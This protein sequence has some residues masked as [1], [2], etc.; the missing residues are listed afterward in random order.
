M[1]GWSSGWVNTDGTTAV[2]NGATLNFTHNL[3]TTDFT[4]SAY[5]ADDTNGTNTRSI[6]QFEI[7]L[8]ANF[9]G[10]QIQNIDP[11]TLTLQLGSSGIVQFT[12]T[13]ANGGSISYDGKYIKVVA[14]A[15][16]SAPAA[17]T[18]NNSSI[19]FFETPYEIEEPYVSMAWTSVAGQGDWANSG[20]TTLVVVAS[21]HDGDI[22][23][24]SSQ[25]LKTRAAD[26]SAEVTIIHH[27]GTSATRTV[28]SEQA[29]I[30]CSI[31]GSFEYFHNR[32]SGHATIRQFRVIGYMA[33]DTVV[34]GAGDLCKILSEDSGYQMFRNGLTMQWMSSPAF[35]TES[36]QVVNFPIPFAAKPFKVVAGTRFPSAAI[37]THETIQTTSWN[38]TS[39]TIFAQSITA[40]FNPVYADIIAI[41]IA[42]VTDCPGDSSDP[43]GTKISNLPSAT[44]LKD[45]DLFVISKENGNDELYDASLNLKLSDLSDFIT[46]RIPPLTIKKVTQSFEIVGFG[47]TDSRGWT[48]GYRVTTR[49]T[50]MTTGAYIASQYMDKYLEGFGLGEPPNHDGYVRSINKNQVSSASLGRAYDKA[51][52]DLSG[53]LTQEQLLQIWSIDNFSEIFIT[54]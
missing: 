6:D 41:G 37:N 9:Y 31:D 40:G 32:D 16:I 39:V 25:T 24:N 42:E 52:I 19:V 34:P 45:D 18:T 4:F 54:D 44:N 21:T 50:N 29:F 2:A 33:K 38:A 27:G 23:G 47:H 26:G 35:T 49:V 12:N 46:S 53:E 22:G 10:S 20:A 8:G 7:D 30:E 48:A 3:E 1:A 51:S 5:L 28:T 36:S 13:G 17:K 11:N 15:A 14:I 43:Q